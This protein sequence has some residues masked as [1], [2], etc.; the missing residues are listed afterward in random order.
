[1]SKQPTFKTHIKFSKIG[2]ILN[3]KYN[4]SLEEFKKYVQNNYIN[5]EIIKDYIVEHTIEGQLYD[6]IRIINSYYNNLTLKDDIHNIKNIMNTLA[7]ASVK[8]QTRL[9]Q[10]KGH[11]IIQKHEVLRE[12]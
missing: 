6:V 7:R 11:S 2:D 4:F 1:M 8:I 9:S 10:V 5:A 12:Y 3:E